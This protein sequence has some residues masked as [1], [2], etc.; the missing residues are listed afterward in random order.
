MNQ[1]LDDITRKDLISYRL[2]RSRETLREVDYL[3]EGLFFQRRGQQTIL[4]LLLCGSG[5]LDSKPYRDDEPCRSEV[6]ILSSFCK[7]RSNR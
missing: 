2:G 5:S 3:I 4:R 6:S 1:N 7:N